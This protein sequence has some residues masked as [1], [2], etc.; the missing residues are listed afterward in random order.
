M[1]LLVGTSGFGHAEWRGPF[2]P[3]KLKPADMLGYY[4]L[5]LRTVEAA[6]AG[7]P[8]P[9]RLQR[10]VAATPGD[11][12]FALRA[13]RRITHTGRL[14]GVDADVAEMYSRA[15]LLG[16]KL[17]P[18][19]F[20]CP[21][22][23]RKDVALLD[24]FL[25]GLPEAAHPVIEFRSRSWYA[26]DVLAVLERHGAALCVADWDDVTK[27]APIVPTARFGYFRMRGESY[28]DDALE[29]WVNRILAQPW[30]E[31]FVFFQRRD[32]ALAAK[33]ALRMLEHVEAAQPLPKPLKPIAKTY[34]DT[35]PLRNRQR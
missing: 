17:G 25:G 6:S 3:D 24:A 32:R 12:V 27:R 16:H 15:Q 2:Y 5:R 33:L 23:L 35:L 9:T 1:R 22:S 29:S 7:V 13:S 8:K 31:A 34:G 21:P 20:Q 14:L 26:D 18:V 4:A 28:S 19:L 11:F 30:R 10:W